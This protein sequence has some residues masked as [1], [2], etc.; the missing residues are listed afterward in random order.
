MKRQLLVFLGCVIF[1]FSSEKGVAVQHHLQ[2]IIRNSQLVKDS[3]IS[4]DTIHHKKHRL[5]AALLAFP[6]GVFGTHRMYLGTSAKVPILYIITAGGFFGILPFID[7]VLI[8]LNKDIN[9]T[10]AHNRHTFMWHKE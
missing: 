5:V 4:K 10:Y 7:F 3:T 1:I 2:F 6:L 9:N 8:L